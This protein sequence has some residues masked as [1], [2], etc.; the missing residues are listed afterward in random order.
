MQEYTKF[1]GYIYNGNFCVNI[2]TKKLL[3]ALSK[4]SEDEEFRILTEPLEETD[5]KKRQ[6]RILSLLKTIGFPDKPF[7]EWSSLSLKLRN[8]LVDIHETFR[9][10]GSI[11]LTTN[12]YPHFEDFLEE[13]KSLSNLKNEQED[14]QKR[15]REII[16]KLNLDEKTK[17]QI[18]EL[19]LLAYYRTEL[20]S[21]VQKAEYYSISLFEE[22]AKRL[23]LSYKQLVHMTDDEIKRSLSKEKLI[24]PVEQIESRFENYYVELTN[25]E[26]KLSSP[27]KEIKEEQKILEIKGNCASQGKAVGKVRILRNSSEISK[28]K[29]GEVLVTFMTTPDYVMAMQKAA[30]IVTNDGG[31]TCHAAIVSR[32]LGVPCIVGTEI[33]TRVLN[34]GDLVEVDATNGIVKIIQTRK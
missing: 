2:A 18:N 1:V 16:E 9:Y 26:V 13:I 22:I 15:K 10:L 34:D 20:L 11:F 33:A 14:L 19:T 25:G 8:E 5:I 3:E 23:N 4:E 30:A 24:I 29:Q 12:N 31:L 28:M 21:Y 17:K 7:P 6:R 32:E 27:E